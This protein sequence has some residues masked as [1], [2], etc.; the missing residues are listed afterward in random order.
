VKHV[1]GKVTSTFRLGN[2]FLVEDL[3]RFII[4]KSLL[5][6]EKEKPE[7]FNFF[8]LI[9]IQFASKF[10]DGERFVSYWSLNLFLHTFPLSHFGEQSFRTSTYCGSELLRIMHSLFSC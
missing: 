8:K 5:R 7:L 9:L 2:L 10:A 3:E 6:W 1:N 4:F